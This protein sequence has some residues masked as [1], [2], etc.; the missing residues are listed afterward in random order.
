M[1]AFSY[2][3]GTAVSAITLATAQCLCATPTLAVSSGSASMTHTIYAANP[4]AAGPPAVGFS[5]NNP[6]PMAAVA[7]APVNQGPA[8][9]AVSQGQ[10]SGGNMQVAQPPT[11]KPTPKPVPT[12]PPGCA[13]LGMTTT[14][15]NIQC[16]D[17]SLTASQNGTVISHSFLTN[18]IP[19]NES[20]TSNCSWVFQTAVPT[21][22]P[23]AV[24]VTKGYSTLSVGTATI[25]SGWIGPKPYTQ[26]FASPF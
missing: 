20:M 10:Q 11:P 25:P 14:V 15:H 23:L 22:V 3:F 21:N 17:L 4:C 12:M 9:Q 16:S 24:S 1:S 13:Y 26:S 19:T 6:M 2:R 18:S 7:P 5:H 8:S